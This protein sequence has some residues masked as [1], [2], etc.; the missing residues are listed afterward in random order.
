[1]NYHLF[2]IFVIFVIFLGSSI[3]LSN[4]WFPNYKYNL[5]RFIHKLLPWTSRF[6]SS[7]TITKPFHNPNSEKGCFGCAPTGA[8]GSCPSNGR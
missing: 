1:M 7:D 6:L 5:L 2:E 8:C 4:R 3:Y